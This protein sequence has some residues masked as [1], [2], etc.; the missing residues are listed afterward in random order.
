MATPSTPEVP[1]IPM[2]PAEVAAS[3]TGVAA[4]KAARA[5]TGKSTAAK[6][7]AVKSSAAKATAAKSVP[8]VAP[9]APV[10]PV[11]PSVVVAAVASAPA[12]VVAPPAPPAAHVQ[13]GVPAPTY[14]APTNVLAIISL[15][16]SLIGIHLA[17]IVT[18]HIALSQIRR[19]GEQGRGLAIAGLIVG[20]A[21]MALTLLFIVI[22]IGFFALLSAGIIAGGSG[23]GN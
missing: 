23:Y 1:P 22:Y 13:Y 14:A 3:A 5:G 9:V 6:S 20:Y 10:A 19:T 2:P 4:P 18:G 8:P 7:S 17:G 21:L 12:A 11:E 16:T 15:V